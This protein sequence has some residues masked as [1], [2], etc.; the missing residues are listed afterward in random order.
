MTKLLQGDSLGIQTTVQAMLHVWE[1]KDNTDQTPWRVLE[2]GLLLVG[3]CLFVSLIDLL[4][5][6]VTDPLYTYYHLHFLM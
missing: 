4:I 2:V 5:L 6:F 1:K 3:F